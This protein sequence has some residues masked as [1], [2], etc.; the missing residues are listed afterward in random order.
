[1]VLI[2][3]GLW[4]IY[5]LYLMKILIKAFILVCLLI[6]VSSKSAS[7]KRPAVLDVRTVELQANT[8]TSFVLRNIDEGKALM[9]SP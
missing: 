1:M 2:F 8:S 6:V 3:V 4:I 9:V 5:K 7:Q